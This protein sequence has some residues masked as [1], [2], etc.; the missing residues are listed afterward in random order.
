MKGTHFYALTSSADMPS[1]IGGFWDTL[2]QAYFGELPEFSN[3]HLGA[4][5]NTSLRLIIVG[6]FL[7]LA[8][9]GF[10]AVY[11]KQILGRFVRALLAENCLSPE[12]GKTLPEMNYADKLMIRRAVRKSPSLR[13]V[14]KCA[15]E[16]AHWEALT[17]KQKKANKKATEFRIDPDIHHFYIP[18]DMKYMADVKFEGKGNT[19][20]GAIAFAAGMIVFMLV[21]LGALPF[22]LSLLNDFLEMFNDTS[23]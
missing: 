14:V 6:I 4:L 18:E 10:V 17:E 8:L 23:V 12:S 16:E 19:W 20:F 15:E 7:G 3:I 13:R 21:V 11:N 22:L 2:Y 1:T 9:G 5:G